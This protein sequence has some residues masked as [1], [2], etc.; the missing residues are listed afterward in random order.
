LDTRTS[1]ITKLVQE[2]VSFLLALGVY[3]FTNSLIF[4]VVAVVLF[5]LAMSLARKYLFYGHRGFT[6]T[7]PALALFAVLVFVVSGDSV[8]TAF[9][10]LS[11]LLH[12]AIDSVF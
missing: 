12:V 8:L 1:L 6:H 7:L 2:I 9:T 3:L 4:A 11:Y 5:Y 10:G